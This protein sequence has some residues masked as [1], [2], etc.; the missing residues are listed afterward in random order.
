V[1]DERFRPL[2]PK[3]VRIEVPPKKSWWNAK[4]GLFAHAVAAVLD[5]EP[6]SKAYRRFCLGVW[7]H[8]VV[9]RF[10]YIQ[11]KKVAG[12]GTSKA[13]ELRVYAK[14]YAGTLSQQIK[15]YEPDLILGCGVGGGSPAGLLAQY[16]LTDGQ[17]QR[18]AKTGATWWRFTKSPRPRAMVQLWHPAWR[19]D[20]WMLYD[21]VWGSVEEVARRLGLLA[22]RPRRRRAN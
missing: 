10:G 3:G 14:T 12:G 2:G 22:R 7:N 11:I 17:K 19:G 15:L 20:R 5:G 9:N 21:D 8:A 18:T 16:V 1:S 6:A 13:K 4:A